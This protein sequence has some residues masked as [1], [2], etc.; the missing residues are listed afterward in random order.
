MDPHPAFR[1][2]RLLSRVFRG[3]GRLS[4]AID[5]LVDD[6]SRETPERVL[7]SSQ[8]NALAV[9]IFLSLNLGVPSVPIA[10]AM[11]DDPLQSL[12]DVNLLGLIDLLRR[13]TD[14]RQ[15]IISTHDERFGRILERKLRPI[16]EDKRTR[17][18]VGGVH[19]AGR[20]R[21][22]RCSR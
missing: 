6:K 2:V 18:L 4:A 20:Q 7:S 10:T 21:M 14:R 13:L 15:L 3:K 16:A 5:D 17:V 22:W 12:D 11:L 9:A 8:M 19:R 1:S